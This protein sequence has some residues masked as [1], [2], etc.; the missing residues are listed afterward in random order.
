MKNNYLKIVLIWLGIGIITTT[1][2]QSKY[3]TILKEHP[4]SIVI[5]NSEYWKISTALTI[6]GALFITAI[7]LKNK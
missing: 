3:N 2:L 1:F 4:K 7:G 5:S 6:G